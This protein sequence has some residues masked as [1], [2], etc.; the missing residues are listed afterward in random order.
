MLDKPTS[1]DDGARPSLLVAMDKRSQELW[2]AALVAIAAARGKDGTLLMQICEDMHLAVASLMKNESEP[3]VTTHEPS[4]ENI[5]LFLDVI[6]VTRKVHID[7][8]HPLQGVATD[9]Y[10][11]WVSGI[12]EKHAVFLPLLLPKKSSSSREKKGK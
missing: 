8:G 7:A 4:L 6:E 1:T 3:P 5:T 2:G 12:K 10:H 11:T 9:K